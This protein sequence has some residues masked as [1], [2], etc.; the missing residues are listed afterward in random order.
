MKLLKYNAMFDNFDG[1]FDTWKKVNTVIMENMPPE[2]KAVWM[3]N[4]YTGIAELAPAYFGMH[5]IYRDKNE[6]MTFE[7]TEEQWTWFAMKWL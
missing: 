7:F 6:S 3:I 2:M 1:T 4:G 5:R